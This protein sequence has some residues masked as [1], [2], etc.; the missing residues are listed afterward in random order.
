M[1]IVGWRG[2]QR[3]GKYEF[4]NRTAAGVVEYSSYKQAQKQGCLKGLYIFSF[5]GGLLLVALFFGTMGFR[6]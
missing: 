2:M 5:V 4:E 1:T 3:I 6:R